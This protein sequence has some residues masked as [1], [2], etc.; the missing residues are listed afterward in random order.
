MP[1]ER[2]G[3]T[4]RRLAAMSVDAFIGAWNG[5]S[6]WQG[7]RARSEAIMTPTFVI[8]GDIDTQFIIDGS[9]SLAATIPGAELAV[10]SQTGHSPQ[11]ER[12]ALFNAALGEFLNRVSGER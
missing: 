8:Y 7:T 10:I 2:L 3:E 12:P 9:R 11:W 6:A 5:L 1:S 4:K